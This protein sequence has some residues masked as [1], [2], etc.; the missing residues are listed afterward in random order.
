MVKS[1]VRVVNDR[2]LE[3]GDELTFFYLSTEW[4][5]VEPFICQYSAKGEKE[6][7]ER[8]SAGFIRTNWL[9]QY[10]INLLARERPEYWLDQ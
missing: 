2:P 9:N 6:C 5:M 1:E 10:I 3:V 7:D 4:D 8:L